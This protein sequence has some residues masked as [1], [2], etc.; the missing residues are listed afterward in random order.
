[1]KPTDS[2]ERTRITFGTC[3]AI[4][5]TTDCWRAHVASAKFTSTFLRSSRSLPKSVKAAAWQA[6]SLWLPLAGYMAAAAVVRMPAY[7]V[8]LVSLVWGWGDSPQP[9]NSLR[10]GEAIPSKTS[11]AVDEFDL[12]FIR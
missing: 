3:Q 2:P 4:A 10:I 12:S 6:S 8:I 1:M 5:L 7:V 9:L 11:T